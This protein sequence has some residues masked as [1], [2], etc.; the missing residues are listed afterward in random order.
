MIS[1]DSKLSFII[2]SC[3]RKI[4]KHRPSIHIILNCLKDF[5]L[6]SS[7]DQMKFSFYVN[8]ISKAEGI[9]IDQDIHSNIYSLRNSWRKFELFHFANTLS[10]NKDCQIIVSYYNIERNH[11]SSEDLRILE[12]NCSQNIY[13][14]YYMSNC[15]M[16][17]HGF[18]KDEERAF[19]LL[20]DYL[21]KAQYESS[22]HPVIL[23]LLGLCHKLGVGTEMSKSEAFRYYELSANRGYS[24]GQSN[25]G[26]CYEEGTG[27]QVD[28]KEAFHYHA[29]ATKQGNK[30]GFSNFANCYKRALEPKLT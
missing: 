7:F 22:F 5:S 8:E 13:A 4:P 19:Q 26:N 14:A 23:N 30:Y 3:L 6:R 1:K 24:S 21:S 25:L 10:S 27:A 9:V 17:G 18:E 29:L 16:D 2:E 15:L 20:I 11:F 12:E 28:E